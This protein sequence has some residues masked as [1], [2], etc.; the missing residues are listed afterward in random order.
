MHREHGHAAVDDVHVILGRDVGNRAAAAD[1]DAAELGGLERD[2]GIVHDL[3]HLGDELGRRVVAAALAARSRVLVE[4][5]ASAHV[6]GVLGLEDVRIAGVERGGD[7]GGQHLAC[8]ERATQLELLALSGEL[9][10]LG[11]GVLE[12]QRLH[13]RSAH[14]TDLL[15]VDQHGDGGAL[16]ILDGELGDERRVGADA[17]VLAVAD[18]HGA[19]EAH[20]ARAA[21][22]H[23]LEFGGEEVLLLDAVVLGEVLKYGSFD[24][25]LLGDLLPCGRIVVELVLLEQE[26]PAAHDHVEIFGV[27]DLL[28]VLLHLLL[29]QMGKQVRDAEH[30]VGRIL[31]HA[32]LDGPAGLEGDDAMDGQRERDPLVLLDAA[33]V[34]RV[35]QGYVGVLVERVLLG[36]ETR[37][38]D[39]GAQDVEAVLERVGAEHRQ[40]EG[41]AMGL[42]VDLV[43][44]LELALLLDGL[45][46]RLVPGLF[47]HGDRGVHALALGLVLRDEL[48]VVA[49]EF[50]EFVE[51]LV[52][53]ALPCVLAFHE[54]PPIWWSMQY[55]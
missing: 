24:R 45:G 35:E 10:D 11:D 52:A 48:D 25:L 33:I 30:G 27:D 1:V 13:A 4:D 19:V 28:G 17:V 40:D 29:A 31:A 14:G 12:E 41:L 18:H 50:F 54:H 47:R 37:R 2:A 22:R 32:N 7:I 16:G 42:G 26:R 51:V 9:H 46:E 23:Y 39:V 44:G 34:M 55:A 38:V 15:L 20:L 53:I 36:V 3:A 8:A 6:G 5:K 43:A 49:A 21:S